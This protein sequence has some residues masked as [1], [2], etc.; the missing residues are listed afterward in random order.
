MKTYIKYI[1]AVSMIFA[2]GV[3]AASTVS[4]GEK[5]I[6]HNFI[7]DTGQSG[8]LPSGA[9]FA[10]T[11]PIWQNQVDSFHNGRMSDQAQ[12]KGT[13]TSV[14]ESNPIWGQQCKCL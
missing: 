9:H 2:I 11:A 6:Y 13:P 14:S 4:A 3:A 8:T 7:Y 1:L 5:P 10:T 12:R